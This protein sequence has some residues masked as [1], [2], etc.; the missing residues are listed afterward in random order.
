M[1]DGRLQKTVLFQFGNIISLV[2]ILH[3]LCFDCC[4]PYYLLC[5]TTKIYFCVMY[6]FSV[7]L[8]VIMENVGLKKMSLKNKSYPFIFMWDY[9]LKNIT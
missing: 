5:A 3:Q 7:I 1:F 2:I 9:P 8:V 4:A 6:S